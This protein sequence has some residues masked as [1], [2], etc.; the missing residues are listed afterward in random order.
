[1]NHDHSQGMGK[2]MLLMLICC[3]VPL[4][5]ILAVSVFGLSLGPLQAFAP[6]L[7]VLLCPIMM[8]F[9]MRGM[10]HDHGAAGMHHHTDAPRQQ[11]TKQV[12]ETAQG[13]VKTTA[14]VGQEKCH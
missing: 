1:M 6:Y 12:P 7:L 3:L 4:G 8:F 10:G 14:A 2:H 9:M 5:L 11:P 13:A